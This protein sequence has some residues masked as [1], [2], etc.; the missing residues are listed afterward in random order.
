MAHILE[1][2]SCTPYSMTVSDGIPTENYYR[3]FY[4]IKKQFYFKKQRSPQTYFVFC[5]GRAFP[6]TDAAHQVERA[7]RASHIAQS[8]PGSVALKGAGPMLPTGGRC[9][10]LSIGAAAAKLRLAICLPT[11]C[12]CACALQ[13]AS[14]LVVPLIPLLPSCLLFVPAA[15]HLGE[16]PSLSVSGWLAGHA[17]ECSTLLPCHA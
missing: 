1:N 3:Q 6:S 13:T 16:R 4:F 8:R 15:S 7:D 10:R 5:G 17:Q 11:T 12:A 14:Q 9:A 2:I